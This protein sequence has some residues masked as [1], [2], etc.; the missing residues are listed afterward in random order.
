[1]FQRARV[2]LRGLVDHGGR[3]PVRFS[4]SPGRAGQG[5]FDLV[6]ALVDQQQL[7]LPIAREEACA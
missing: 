6:I 7:V 4:R 5:D 3:R 1:M 2:R